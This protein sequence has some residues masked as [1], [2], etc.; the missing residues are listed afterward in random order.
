MNKKNTAYLFRVHSNER[1]NEITRTHASEREREHATAVTLVTHATPC[2]ARKRNEHVALQLLRLRTLTCERELR[3][4]QLSNARVRARFARRTPRTLPTTGGQIACVTPTPRRNAGFVGCSGVPIHQYV[5]TTA[6]ASVDAERL[7]L[8]NHSFRISGIKFISLDRAYEHFPKL[9]KL[10]IPELKAR[11]NEE[12]QKCIDAGYSGH[13][14][15]PSFEL[16]MEDQV[17]LRKFPPHNPDQLALFDLGPVLPVCSVR[18][19]IW[20]CK[21]GERDFYDEGLID[22]KSTEDDYPWEELD[23][24]QGD[25]GIPDQIDTDRATARECYQRLI[26]SGFV[27]TDRKVFTRD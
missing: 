3:R 23:M 20:S 16:F 6:T 13:A 25:Y 24:E 11:C 22:I 7:E 8:I 19:R 5:M 9:A 26:E 14:L 27:L 17:M 12:R 4:Q 10:T 21:D 1:T 2:C 18:F 15:P